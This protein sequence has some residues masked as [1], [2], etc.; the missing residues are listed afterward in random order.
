MAVTINAMLPVACRLAS[1]HVQPEG[2]MDAIKSAPAQKGYGASVQA[3]KST[4]Q[5]ARLADE[6]AA[7]PF[8]DQCLSLLASLVALDCSEPFRAPVDKD[9]HPHYYQVSISS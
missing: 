8:T 2:A 4:A 5:A 1:S 3:V 7:T 6:P 9:Q